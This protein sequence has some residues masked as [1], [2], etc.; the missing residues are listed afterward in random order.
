MTAARKSPPMR[1][2]FSTS[3]SRIACAAAPPCRSAPARP[4]SRR[5][6]GLIE[7]SGYRGQYIL[8][9]ARAADGD[10]AGALARYRDMAVAGSRTRRDETGAGRPG[11]SRH[12]RQPGHWPCD[13]P[14]ARRGRR[15]CRAGGAG[16]DGLEAGCAA[17]SAARSRSMPPTSPIPPRRWRWRETS[18]RDG[19][20]STSWSAMSAAA[21]PCRPGK[22]TAAEWRRVMDLNLFAATNMIEAARPDHAARQRR[23]RDR[24]RLLDL[25][26]RRARRARDLFRGQ[27]GAQRH[28]AGPRPAAGA[29]GHP[30]QR[31]GA[32]QYPV[33]R[34]H[35]G[36]QAR[37][38]QSRAST[39]CWRARCR[40]AGWARRKRSPM[41]SAFLASPRAAFITGTVIVADG[42][43]LRA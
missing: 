39:T 38:K 37:R 32:R 42:G 10:H 8:Q 2:A 28:R 11:R 13:R 43:Q 9:T 12:R 25:R 4:I 40:S 35:L 33:R 34:R 27:G 26:A 14:D 15:A 19:A 41:S 21:P 36:A 23:P 7:Q 30:H 17:K 3:M 5:R 1:R 24:L 29:G 18:R 16:R 6:S 22:E 31:G 20:G